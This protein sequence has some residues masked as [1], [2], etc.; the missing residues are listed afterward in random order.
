M[1]WVEKVSFGSRSLHS[2]L[3]TAFMSFLKICNIYIFL[4]WH[5]VVKD[6]SYFPISFTHMAM[7]RV[8]RCERK[9]DPSW[10]ATTSSNL[11]EADVA[12]AA[13]VATSMIIPLYRYFWPSWIYFDLYKHLYARK[14][15]YSHCMHAYTYLYTHVHTVC[16]CV[17]VEA[18]CHI[19]IIWVWTGACSKHE[20]PSVQKMEQDNYHMATDDNSH[21]YDI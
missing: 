8:G 1:Q 19:C 14:S 2:H 13:G 11:Q 18:R 21:W 3:A 5:L 16:V 9:P 7:P 10:P 6:L 20:W 12:V 15:T 4:L 17:C